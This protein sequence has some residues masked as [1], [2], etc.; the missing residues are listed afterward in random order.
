MLDGASV[1]PSSTRRASPTEIAIDQRAQTRESKARSAVDQPRRIV[2]TTPAAS[3]QPTPPE[4]LRAAVDHYFGASL[5]RATRY[6]TMLATD[7][8]VRGL[9]GPREV[10]RLW[11]RHLLN[12]VVL[13]E[14]IPP[15]AVVADV[16]SGAGL[17]GVVLAIA[18]PDLR[19]ILIEPQLRRTRFLQEVVTALGL[20]QV[21]V[22]RARA[23][24]AVADCEPADVVVS[25]AVAPLDRLAAWSLPLARTGGTMLALKGASAH[26]EVEAHRDAVR[27]AGGGEPLVVTCGAEWL[28]P[29]ATAI[30]VVRESGASPSVASG[31]RGSSASR[32]KGSQAGGSWTSDARASGSR[33]G[34]SRT[35]GSRSGETQAR[36]S[37]AGGARTHRSRSSR[38]P[39]RRR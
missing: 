32:S 20:A 9:I 24:Q 31:E 23:E 29:P 2:T 26:D 15:D 35:S 39:R 11:D 17:P 10:P 19:V 3:E 27:R 16:G 5:K 4:H 28:D 22:V 38:R 14:R 30:E 36:G 8:V 7:G 34:G 13:V 33:A 12:S 1:N 6:A 37:Q 25:R 18:R 21:R